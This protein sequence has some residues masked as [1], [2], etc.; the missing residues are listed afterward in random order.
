VTLFSEAIHHG[1]FKFDDLV[2][3]SFEFALISPLMLKRI[4]GHKIDQD[5][6][7]IYTTEH[8]AA[9]HK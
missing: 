2:K 8:P 3:R 1:L 5:A 4:S 9:Q 7:E 6:I